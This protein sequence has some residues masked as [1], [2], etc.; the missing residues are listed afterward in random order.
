MRLVLILLLCLNLNA[1]TIISKVGNASRLASDTEEFL[2]SWRDGQ[3]IS[4]Q[5]DSEYIGTATKKNSAIVFISFFFSGYSLFP[6]LL[7]INV[8]KI[9]YVTYKGGD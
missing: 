9:P 8:C 5:R 3:I 4:I 6:P 7:K 1:I 2:R